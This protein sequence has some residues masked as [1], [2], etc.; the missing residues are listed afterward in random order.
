MRRCMYWLGSLVAS[1]MVL[2]VV[3]CQQENPVEQTGKEVTEH[4][5][6]AIDNA[7]GVGETLEHAAERTAEQVKEAEE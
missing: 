4:S 1:M 5:R 3:G 7:E 6:N 2:V